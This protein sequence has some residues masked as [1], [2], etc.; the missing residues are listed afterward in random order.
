MPVAVFMVGCAFGTE[1]YNGGTLINMLIVSLGVAVASFGKLF[2]RHCRTQCETHHCCQAVQRQRKCFCRGAE[3]RRHWCCPPNVLNLHRV[4]TS[5]AGANLVAAAGTETE[6]H[7]HSVL[8][9]SLLLCLP[10]A[11]LRDAGG[12]QDHERPLCGLQAWRPSQQ[13]CCS[14]W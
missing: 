2:I 5:G 4:N 14:I 9:S 1:K 7:H 8:Y 13:C 10:S 12:S 11:A 6:S 3:L